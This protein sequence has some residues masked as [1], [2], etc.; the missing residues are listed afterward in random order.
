MAYISKSQL[1]VI[2]MVS[3]CCLSVG[4]CSDS[5]IKVGFSGTLEG[6]YSDLGVQGRN[7]ALF[8]IEQINSAGGIDGRKLELIVRN[9]GTTPEEAVKADSELI[10]AGVV[11]I[12]GHMTSV[13]SMAALKEHADKDIVYI[14]P[15]TSTSLIQGRKDNFFRVIATLTDLS[16]SLAEFAVKEMGKRRLAVVWDQSNSPF[17]EPYKSSFITAFNQNGGEFAGEIGYT[18]EK[19]SVN[20]Q[21]IIDQLKI[22]NPDAVVLVTAARDLAAFAQYSKL[23]SAPWTVFSS[24][25]GYT[26]ELVQTGGKSV[27]GIIFAV[28]FAED[29]PEPG[30]DK[31]RSDFEERFGWPPNFAAVFGYEAVQVF[32]EAVRLNGGRTKDLGAVIPGISFENSLVGPYHIDEFGDV[33]RDGHIVIVKDGEFVTVHRGGK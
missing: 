25:W 4:A 3:V 22:L 12:L 5:P 8:A 16:E 28:H 9:D 20:W 7:G 29:K 11:A 21:N 10:D 1:I 23:N 32:A 31:F 2:I 19:G 33:N 14:S 27:E 17:T 24:M 26:K 15:T 13:Q 18:P 6:K 30:Y